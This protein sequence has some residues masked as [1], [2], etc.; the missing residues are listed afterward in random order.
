[1]IRIMRNTAKLNRAA[2]WHSNPA[3]LDSYTC[4][5]ID[6][7]D[8]NLNKSETTQPEGGHLLLFE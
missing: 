2:N 6:T 3:M 1:M 4:L 7:I 8:S 5:F